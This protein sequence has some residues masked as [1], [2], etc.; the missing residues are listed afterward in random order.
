MVDGKPIYVFYID[1]SRLYDNEIYIL[2]ELIIIL[3]RGSNVF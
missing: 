1:Q 2:S 3:L